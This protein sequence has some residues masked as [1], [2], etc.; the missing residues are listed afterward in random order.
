MMQVKAP[1]TTDSP[2]VRLA[3][4]EDIPALAATL[5]AA[6]RGYV[7]TDWLL[8]PGQ[9]DDRL[10]QVFALVLQTFIHHVGRVWTSVD[11][12][13]VMAWMSPEAPEILAATGTDPAAFN[14]HLYGERAAL[15][16]VA[17][18]AVQALHP[19][20]PHWHFTLMATHPGAGC[21]GSSVLRTGLEL[22]DES[23]LPVTGETSTARHV[24]YYGRFGFRV[25]G[26]LDP[27]GGAPHVWVLRRD[28]R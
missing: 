12:S 17:E 3:T 4:E 14:E 10:P 2:V 23:G 6:F 22:A 27:P 15:V 28:P 7:W 16:T 9:G 18:Q 11:L 25:I 21:V 8:P 19:T 26:E 13:S 20:E 5:A 1:R 24:Q